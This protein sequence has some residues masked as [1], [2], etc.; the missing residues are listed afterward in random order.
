L[1]RVASLRMR[2]LVSKEH[3]EIEAS[4]DAIVLHSSNEF[5]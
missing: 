2:Y 1:V 3:N 5:V 4:I